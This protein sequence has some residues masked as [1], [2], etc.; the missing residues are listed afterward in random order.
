MWYGSLGMNPTFLTLLFV[1][2]P[3]VRLPL[4]TMQRTSR[5]T[6]ILVCVSWYD[7]YRYINRRCSIH[8]APLCVKEHLVE[9][10][11]TRT[12]INVVFGQSRTVLYDPVRLLLQWE[13]RFQLSM[14]AHTALKELP[15]SAIASAVILS[16]YATTAWEIVRVDRFLGEFKLKP[17]NNCMLDLQCSPIMSRTPDSIPK[18]AQLFIFQLT[19]VPSVPFYAYSYSYSTV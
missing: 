14:L 16:L 11:S 18:L 1:G 9:W 7:C 2:S 8:E 17:R 15:L 4:T 12:M 5:P 19:D 13:F 6:G 10:Y 3:S